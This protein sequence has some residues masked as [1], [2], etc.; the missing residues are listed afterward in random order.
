MVPF[1]K[2]I[3][4]GKYL[5][6]TAAIVPMTVMCA[7]ATSRIVEQSLVATDTGLIEAGRAMGASRIHI[8]FRL[9]VPEALAPLILGYTFLFFGV[10]D[11]SAVAG[12]IGAGGLGNFALTYGYNNFNNVVMWVAI[13]V[14]IVM[15][16]LVQQ[17]GNWLARHFLR[18]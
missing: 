4:S 6:S 3:M 13:A 16:Q 5:G 9:L 1:T 8:L 2:L 14:I 10:L 7:M 15:V 17:L 11:M 18:R 12:A